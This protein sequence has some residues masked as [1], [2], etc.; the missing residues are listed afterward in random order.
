MATKCFEDFYTLV[1]TGFGWCGNAMRLPL[2][3]A[4]I[5]KL[6]HPRNV[7]VWLTQAHPHLLADIQNRFIPVRGGEGVGRLLPSLTSPKKRTHDDHNGDFLWR[8]TAKSLPFW[9]SDGWR[10]NSGFLTS[11]FH[12]ASSCLYLRTIDLRDHFRNRIQLVQIRCFKTNLW[13]TARLYTRPALM[14]SNLLIC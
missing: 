8:L 7:V 12:K 11:F 9:W 2:H 5:H 3:N 4:N 6:N 13:R 10:L 14:N 1:V